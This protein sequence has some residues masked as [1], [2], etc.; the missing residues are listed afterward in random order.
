MKLLVVTQAADLDHPILGFFHRWLEEL[1]AQGTDLTVI[2]QQ[3]GRTE[4][5]ARVLSLG[6]EKGLSKTAQVL[7]FWRLIIAESGRYDAVF[8]HMTPVWVLLGWPVW[9]LLRKRVH[10]WY[11]APGGGWKLRWAVRLVRRTFTSTAKGMPI[12]APRVTVTGQG[13]DTTLFSPGDGPRDP[14]LVVT[15]GRVT[16]VKRYDLLLRAFAELPPSHRFFIA[17]GPVTAQ[18]RETQAELD[19]LA[20]ELGIAD[21]IETRFLTWPE[22]LSLLRRA[23]LFLHAAEG[24]LDKAVLEAMACECLVVSS[25]RSAPGAIPDEYCAAPAEIGAQANALLRLPADEQR[26]LRRRGRSVVTEQHGLSRLVTVF[27]LAMA[28]D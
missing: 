26:S 13:I 2:A 3:V 19:R 14:A 5:D 17:G 27:L 1:V 4:L 21:R 24:A 11:A 28:R 25:C 16:T 18:D 12:P 9:F 22:V 8:V 7:R 20:R 10:L 23:D 15:V 6:K